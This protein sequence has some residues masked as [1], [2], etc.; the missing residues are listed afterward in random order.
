MIGRETELTKLHE[1][2]QTKKNVCVVSGMG[3]VGKT[4][5][6]RNYSTSDDCK[7]HFSGGVFYLDARS[8]ENI[9]AEIVAVTEYHFQ[10]QIEDILN[11]VTGCEF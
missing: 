5:L 6:V 8:R 11:T 7:A 1:L 4:E 10:A 9:A 2:L 3:G